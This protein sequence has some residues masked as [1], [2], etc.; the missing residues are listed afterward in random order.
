MRTIVLAS[1]IA[2]STLP[3][4]AQS[5]STVQGTINDSSGGVLPGV[6]VTLR[7]TATGV[8]RTVTSDVAGEYLAAALPPG[9]YRIEA[10]LSGFQAQ[11]QEIDADVAR[12]VLLNFRLGVGGVAEQVS[13]IG[14][15]PVIETATVSVG[16]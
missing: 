1:L 9:R 3:P 10:T 2:F 14:S 7:N 4:F 12:T 11:A 6:T 8:E 15:T 5:T 13:V 16:R